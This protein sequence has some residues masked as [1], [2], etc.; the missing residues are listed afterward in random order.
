MGAGHRAASPHPPHLLN[1]PGKYLGPNA[2][3]LYAC[4][5]AG[6]DRGRAERTNLAVREYIH[7]VAIAPMAGMGADGRTCNAAQ[8]KYEGQAGTADRG[9]RKKK[10]GNAGKDG[11]GR[12]EWH[13]TRTRVKYTGGIGY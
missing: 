9:M 2:W 8:R 12:E 5:Q 4:G 6:C 11:R 7:N 3:V 10:K 1:G 13:E